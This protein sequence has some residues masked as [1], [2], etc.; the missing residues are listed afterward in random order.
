MRVVGGSGLVEK[1]II[2]C[3]EI[4][5]DRFLK[6]IRR[7]IICKA[8]ILT[9]EELDSY[10]IE[11]NDVKIIE[12]LGDTNWINRREF[13]SNYVLTDGTAVKSI[14]LRRGN[15]YIVY[16]RCNIPYCVLKISS[17]VTGRIKNRNVREN[18]YLVAEADENGNAIMETI[19]AISEKAFK[20][21]F[22][23]PKQ[24]II[25]KY[26]KAREENRISSIYTQDDFIDSVDEKTGFM[27]NIGR[28]IANTI[29]SNQQPVEGTIPTQS[30]SVGSNPPIKGPIKKNTKTEQNKWQATHRLLDMCD[31]MVGFI[32]KNETTGENKNV[33]LNTAK[34]LAAKSMLSNI[35]LVKNPD[36]GKQYFR[37]V[38][39]SIKHLPSRYI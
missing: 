9:R 22:V 10:N 23:I 36:T 5:P 16:R 11:E 12:W 13:V 28:R 35:T 14:L 38:N 1:N 17:Q 15:T 30:M 29:N 33:S 26:I 4:E 32:V 21:Q 6:A 2:N 7:K 18:S 20:Q 24:D 8:R 31:N 37:G 3:E 34:I 27:S 25:D 39:I 19:A